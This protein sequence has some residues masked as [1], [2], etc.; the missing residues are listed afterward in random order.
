MSDGNRERPD[1]K[2]ALQAALRTYEAPDALHMWAQD[3]ARQYDTQSSRPGI[4]DRRS[5]SRWSGRSFSVATWQVA[6]GLLLAAAAGWGGS[7]LQIRG[8]WG[9]P[10]DQGGSQTV[11]ALVD[12]HVRS[13]IPGHLLD[14]Q[15]TDQHTVKPW[16]AG[17]ADIAPP[18]PELASKGFPLLGGRLDYVQGHGAV[19]LVYGRRRHTINLFVW[20]TLPGERPQE[21]AIRD[22]Y[23]LLHWTTGDLSYWAVTDA[24]TADLSAFRVAYSEG[25]P[26]S[27]TTR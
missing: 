3:Q 14:I 19:A 11:T 2:A 20:R 21:S 24:T 22:G 9:R 5:P 25:P 10:V 7:A 26:P 1:L 6:A 13:M 15:S 18:V 27:P 8:R 17:R 4:S 23:A 16:F 12:T